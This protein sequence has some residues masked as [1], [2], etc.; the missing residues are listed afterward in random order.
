MN[1]IGVK[2]SGA[3]PHAIAPTSQIVTHMTMMLTMGSHGDR[4]DVVN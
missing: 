4:D 3:A 2:C 1:P